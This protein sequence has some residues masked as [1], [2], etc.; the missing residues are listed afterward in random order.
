M[1]ILLALI[2]STISN[3]RQNDAALIPNYGIRGFSM[4]ILL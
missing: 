4:I 3:H 1:L 2:R